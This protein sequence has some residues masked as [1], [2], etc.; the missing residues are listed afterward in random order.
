MPRMDIQ[1]AI[2]PSRI[3]RAFVFILLSH[4]LPAP[5]RGLS[6]FTKE[7]IRKCRTKSGSRVELDSNKMGTAGKTRLI[8]C[9]QTTALMES[10]PCSA[11]DM[12]RESPNRLANEARTPREMA[13]KNSE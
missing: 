13:E 1:A 2:T 6:W 4:S 11:R 8:D 10:K 9:G 5:K 12:R 7:K 3:I